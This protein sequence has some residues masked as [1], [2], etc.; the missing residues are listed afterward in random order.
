MLFGGRS[1]SPT[2]NNRTRNQLTRQ[3]SSRSPI[4]KMTPLNRNNHDSKNGTMMNNTKPGKQN[5]QK[6]K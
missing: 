5:L 2:P 6:S 4:R 3:I 1:I